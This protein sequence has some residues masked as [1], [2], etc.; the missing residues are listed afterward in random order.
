MLNMCNIV[1]SFLNHDWKGIELYRRNEMCV[2]ED[3]GMC[4]KEI[5]NSLAF[6]FILASQSIVYPLLTSK[7]MEIPT[8]KLYLSLDLY[9]FNLS[10]S[11][12][13]SYY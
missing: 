8:S 1:K 4:L 12:C 5:P 3:V 2:S 9:L 7:Q 11:T 10:D 13:L 6:W